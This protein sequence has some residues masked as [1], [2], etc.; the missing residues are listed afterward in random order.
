MRVPLLS[1]PTARTAAAALHPGLQLT[2]QNLATQEA[3]QGPRASRPLDHAGEC[4][5][6]EAQG[7]G[8]AKCKGGTLAPQALTLN[9]PGQEKIQIGGQRRRWKGQRGGAEAE[10]RRSQGPGRQR[11]EKQ[12]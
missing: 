1:A 5:E 4:S 2:I 12:E 11:Q 6:D 9:L 3:S 8:E 7:P 10:G